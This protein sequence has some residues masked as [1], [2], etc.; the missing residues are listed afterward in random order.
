MRKKSIIE[1]FRQMKV[2]TYQILNDDLIV[3]NPTTKPE[4]MTWPMW[5]LVLRK[6]GAYNQD[7]KCA[8][9]NSLLG[10]MQLHHAL[11]SRR[12][13]MGNQ[14]GWM[15]HH[16]LNCICVC[17]Q[18]QTHPTRSIG[19]QFLVKLYGNGPVKQWYNDFPMQSDKINFDYFIN[20]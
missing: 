2:D 13:V 14:F 9:G 20:K 10:G 6:V 18:C 17:T 19:G 15:I 16:T 5:Q 4:H 3:L 8:C 12:D 1:Y 7:Y 11:I